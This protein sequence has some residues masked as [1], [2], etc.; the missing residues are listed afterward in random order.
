[1][2]TNN[3]SY[4]SILKNEREASGAFTSSFAPAQ[5]FLSIPLFIF[6]LAA[7]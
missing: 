3:L 4:Y 5:N 6:R 1:M 7:E 2:K